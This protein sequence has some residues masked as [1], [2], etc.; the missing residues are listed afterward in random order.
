[1]SFDWYLVDEITAVGDTRFRRKS[2]AVFRERLRDAGLLMV[3]HLDRTIREYRT[4]A[5]LLENGQAVYYDDVDAALA[6]HERNMFA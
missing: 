5:L 2:L 1:M 4:S 6:A 3:S